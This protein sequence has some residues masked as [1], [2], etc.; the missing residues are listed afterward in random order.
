[1]P[2]YGRGGQFGFLIRSLTHLT[3]GRLADMLHR[4]TLA[5][6][7]GMAV[8]TGWLSAQGTGAAPEGKG[9]KLS[10]ERWACSSD[11]SLLP[12]DDPTK[13]E[14][15]LS[16][17]APGWDAFHLFTTDCWRIHALGGGLLTKYY[18]S[19]QVVVLDE[20]GRCVILQSDSGK[21]SP[22][23]VVEDGKSCSAWATGDIDPRI[24]GTEIYVGSG[25]GNVYQVVHQ[26]RRGWVTEMVASIP[27]AS[28]SKLIIGDVAP[29]RPGDELIAVTNNGPV[30]EIHP[31]PTK[32]KPF[33]FE[34]IGDLGSRCRDAVLLPADGKRPARIAALLQTGEVALMTRTETGFDRKPMCNEPM[35]IARIA[36][37]PTVRRNAPG[38]VES[39]GVEPEVVYVARTDGL[40][41][42]FSERQDGSWMRDM[43]YAGPTGTRGLA[44]GRFDLD[45]R[46]ETVAVF[47][48]SKKVQLLSA[49]PGEPW[50]VE[51]IY[52]DF[53]GGHW[54]AAVELDG[55]NTTDELV[56]GG[57]SFHVFMLARAPGYGLADVP[58]DPDGQP[59]PPAAHATG[60]RAAAA[61]AA[62]TAGPVSAAAK[63]SI[64][65]GSELLAESFEASALGGVPAGWTVAETASK[66][67]PATWRVETDL[68]APDGRQIV[69]IA[70]TTNSGSTFNLLLSEKT[71][72]ADLVLSVKIR[73]DAGTEDR[74]GGLVWRAKDGNNYYVARWNPIENNLRV[75]KV[76]AGTRTFFQSADVKGT[77]GNWHEILVVAKSA[78]MTV[79]FD[80]VPALEWEDSTFISGGKVGLWSKAD[81]ATSFDL[82]QVVVP[83]PGS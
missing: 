6:L 30:Y 55:R 38:G 2:F 63:V 80:G 48:Y 32:D 20:K 28:L 65:R 7:I 8:A 79:Q 24:D 40:I 52:T 78:K 73:P 54:L 36:R 64:K 68:T 21:W 29:S 26:G 4:S 82:V 12:Q 9:A 50:K 25:G 53:G 15:R 44:A 19:P 17:S 56:G 42:R 18:G 5:A 41:L 35:S 11:P 22:Q 83:K 3:Q 60:Q 10:P 39:P 59:V 51:T 16:G 74:G 13:G 71:Y 77:P 37:K 14:I 62:A 66:V 43:I 57:F 46:T 49:R 67:K 27:D 1:M 33:T 81:A 76:E 34:L 69:Q 58:S 72:P 47:G 61:P 70:E 75:Y 31:G 45:P 23:I